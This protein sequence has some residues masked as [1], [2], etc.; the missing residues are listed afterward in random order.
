M[1]VIEWSYYRHGLPV[2]TI[3]ARNTRFADLV[4]IGVHYGS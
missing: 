4:Q 3:T 2:G 1:A